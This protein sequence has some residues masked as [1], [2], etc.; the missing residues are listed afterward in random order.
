MKARRHSICFQI[1]CSYTGWCALCGPPY[2]IRARMK[3]N[4]R[5]ACLYDRYHK[6]NLCSTEG[7]C[8]FYK[9]MFLWR[10]TKK[11]R[12]ADRSQ[13]TLYSLKHR[14]YSRSF[15]WFIVHLIISE[16]ATVNVRFRKPK[17]RK[18]GLPSSSMY[19]LLNEWCTRTQFFAFNPSPFA[20]APSHSSNL[21]VPVLNVEC[22]G[23]LF[24]CGCCNIP[25][26]FTELTRKWE[27]RSVKGA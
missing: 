16:L 5:V 22:G 11:L 18:W 2:C 7:Q 19:D 27:G 25:R 23:Y 20:K 14:R 12:M 1:S 10:H 6:K 13:N 17:F 24:N 21:L 9:S 4:E 15:L 26:S 3:R 8:N